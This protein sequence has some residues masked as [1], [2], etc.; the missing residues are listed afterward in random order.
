MND[1]A[2]EAYEELAAALVLVYGE[3]SPDAANAYAQLANIALYSNNVEVAKDYQLKALSMNTSFYASDSNG[4]HESIAATL[5]QLGVIFDQ[6]GQY[7]TAYYLYHYKALEIRLHVFETATSNGELATPVSSLDFVFPNAYDCSVQ[8]KH[9]LWDIAESFE[10][11]GLLL[12]QLRTNM[13]TAYKYVVQSLLIRQEHC[14]NVA[15]CKSGTPVTHYL[16]GSS[17]NSIGEILMHFGHHNLAKEHFDLAVSIRSAYFGKKHNIT[18][19]S[20]N[21]QTVINDLID[22]NIKS[23]AR[24]AEQKAIEDGT[25]EAPAA[26]TA[27]DLFERSMSKEANSGN[28]IRHVVSFPDI[29]AGTSTLPTASSVSSPSMTGI[30]KHSSHAVTAF[31]KPLTKMRNASDQFGPLAPIAF[32]ELPSISPP[33]ETVSIHNQQL[34]RACANGH[35]TLY[36]AEGYRDN[37]QYKQALELYDSVYATLLEA[38]GPKHPSLAIVLTSMA[39][40]FEDQGGYEPSAGDGFALAETK[41]RQALSILEDA[42]EPHT[43]ED[44]WIAMTN[45]AAN[46]RLRG[47]IKESLTLLDTCLHYRRQFRSRGVHNSLQVPGVNDL[48]FTAGLDGDKGY[49]RIAEGFDP[50][51]DDLAISNILHQM[52]VCYNTLGV[53]AVAYKHI[54]NALKI[55]Q[56][57]LS[58]LDPLISSSLHVMVLVLIAMNDDK[59]FEEAVQK[60]QQVVKLRE[61]SCGTN[62]PA[63]ATVITTLAFIHFLKRDYAKAG[64]Y[65]ERSM[66]IRE[67]FIGISSLDMVVGLNNMVSLL[68]SQVVVPPLGIPPPPTN[69]A[70]YMAAK[71]EMVLKFCQKNADPDPVPDNKQASKSPKSRMLKY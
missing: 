10:V 35:L 34:D 47:E 23:A 8:L 40:M 56:R 54:D 60:C 20:L 32:E 65:L 25:I 44:I 67:K 57:E 45:L 52:A 61:E 46:C 41:Y 16:I 21:N 43:Q 58:P 66:E 53:T 14:D 9:Q 42:Y 18:I 28:N 33:L 70:I 30:L 17:H 7:M 22:L 68:A 3:N 6:E 15:L 12:F 4:Q 24:M 69:D 59:S 50:E 19:Q 63:Y 13:D 38:H 48:D 1:E 49:A 37:G 51:Q 27:A 71:L 26:V 64:N 31:L 2:R 11:C 62:H 39:Q 55:R 36:D 29:G 5:F